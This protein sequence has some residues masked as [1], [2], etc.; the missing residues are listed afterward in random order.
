MKLSTIVL[1]MA[2]LV[3]AAAV[4][5]VQP[6]TSGTLVNVLGTSCTIGNA[7]FI[8]QNN[9]AGFNGATVN[10]IFGTVP[11]SAD[12]VG[13]VPIVSGSQNGFR[14]VT[15]FNETTDPVTV[16]LSQSN[17]NFSYD[18]RVNGNFQIIA[19]T[20]SLDG[21][22]TQ[23]FLD[24]VTGF[25]SRCFNNQF[26]IQAAPVIQFVPGFGFENTSPDTETLSSPALASVP[27][28]G[29][30]PFNTALDAFAFSPDHA[31]LNSAS[32]LYTIVPQVPL[33]PL[34]KLKYSEIRI[35]GALSTSV[36]G[37]NDA[38]D[39]V[40]TYIDGGGASHGFVQTRHGLQ[41]VTVPNAFNASPEGI[42]NQGDVVGFAQ[43]FTG[44]F[45]GFLFHNRAFTAID[46]P[47]AIDSFPFDINDQ[48]VIA[49]TYRIN[50]FSEHGFR[51]DAA[52]YATVDDPNQN[53][54]G[55][56]V[57][58][59]INNRGEIVGQYLDQTFSSHAF[60]FDS[61]VFRD[62]VVTGGFQPVADDINDAGSVIGTYEDL[63]SFF[64]GYVTQGA[65]FRTVDFPGADGTFPFQI[66]A[67]G[68]IVGQYLDNLGNLHSFLAVRQ[69]DDGTQE[70]PQAH[71]GHS[72]LRRCTSS[73]ALEHRKNMKNP[74]SCPAN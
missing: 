60:V 39:L 62:V 65:D 41:E 19:E 73:D 26:C 47:G 36:N 44:H 17:I 68:Q 54:T 33:P 59:G 16:F 31:T 50:D 21:S 74:F 49:G 45:Q 24:S 2:M 52:G 67:S 1:L 32:F 8:F 71:A 58:V 37:I 63:N 27:G 61:P 4:A 11:L 20:V 10:N 6:C 5:Q 22:A 28:T 34:A 14:L 7:T 40:G 23:V 53:T 25:D 38:G 64:H 9:F 66:N 42:N 13:F 12:M 70:R 3:P 29:G 30:L 43:D 15:N 57:A 55:F 18:L 72:S 46:F 48:G 51:F 35:P 56:T 69:T